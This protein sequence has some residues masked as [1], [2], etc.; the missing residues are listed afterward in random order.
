MIFAIFLRKFKEN[1]VMEM[2]ME[3]TIIFFSLDS[4]NVSSL[5]LFEI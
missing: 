3:R 5:N 1:L 2:T 4:M